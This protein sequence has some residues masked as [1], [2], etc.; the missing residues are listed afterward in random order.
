MQLDEVTIF[1]RKRKY[2]QKENQSEKKLETNET[3]DSEEK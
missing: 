2:R 3:N 1:L